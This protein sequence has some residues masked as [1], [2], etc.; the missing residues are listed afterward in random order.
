MSKLDIAK[1]LM[2]AFNM[3]KRG[4]IKNID[5]LF[6]FAKQQFGQVDPSLKNQ[7]EDTF[8]KGKAAAITETR[9]KDIKTRKRRD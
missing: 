8:K 9:T 2:A 4:D 3:V 5:D 7:I 1:F 6:K